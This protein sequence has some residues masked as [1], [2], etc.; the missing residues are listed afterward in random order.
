MVWFPFDDSA[1]PVAPEEPCE[2]AFFAAFVTA[3]AETPSEQES[4]AMFRQVGT[5]SQAWRENAPEY[6]AWRIITDGDGAIRLNTNNGINNNRYDEEGTVTW[7]W[8]R[9][10]PGS[11]IYNDWT[12]D[13]V[14]FNGITYFVVPWV[15]ATRIYKRLADGTDSML[16]EIPET[17][18]GVSSTAQVDSIAISADGSTLFLFTAQGSQDAILIGVSAST[19]SVLWDYTV[20]SGLSSVGYQYPHVRTRPGTD[21][22]FLAYYD[23]D[24]RPTVERLDFASGLGSAPTQTWK[25]AAEGVSS[26]NTGTALAVGAD[27]LFFGFNNVANTWDGIG[28]PVA[29]ENAYIGVALDMD[30]SELWFIAHA[31]FESDGAYTQRH[32]AAIAGTRV[33]VGVANDYDTFSTEGWGYRVF[34]VTTGSEFISGPFP[35]EAYEVGPVAVACVEPDD[36]PPIFM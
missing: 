9:P 3:T 30:A 22:V 15:D 28:D 36:S 17:Q 33:M 14:T 2:P 26:W 5:A 23:A 32:S 10:V 35:L 31:D 21:T 19:G 7:T 34:N 27:Q 4:I 11:G 16:A 1:I 25:W 13:A 12:A 6:E 24:T 8:T 29:I 20:V 18:F